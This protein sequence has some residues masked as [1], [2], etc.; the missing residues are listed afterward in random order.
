MLSLHNLPLHNFDYATLA[1]CATLDKR[2]NMIVATIQGHL[3][4]EQNIIYYLRTTSLKTRHEAIMG[5]LS[6]GSVWNMFHLL[7]AERRQATRYAYVPSIGCINVNTL[8]TSLI[9]IP[10]SYS[11][12]TDSHAV[13]IVNN[14]LAFLGIQGLEV[15]M[16]DIMYSLWVA[17]TCISSDSS[18]HREVSA[19][20]HSWYAQDICLLKIDTYKHR[21]FQSEAFSLSTETYYVPI[22]WYFHSELPRSMIRTIVLGLIT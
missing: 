10:S 21:V 14:I 11:I 18:L 20:A 1:I 4:R 16:M 12:Y 17:L 5:S 15:S 19:S 6:Y 22:R 9:N 2:I 3:N 7:R 8:N 13:V